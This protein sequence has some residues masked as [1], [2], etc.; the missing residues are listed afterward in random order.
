MAIGLWLLATGSS[1]LRAS[2]RA[3]TRN[4]LNAEGL[5]EAKSQ[6]P[7]AKMKEKWQTIITITRTCNST[8]TTR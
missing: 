4:L 3:Q 8:S 5:P 1:I 6:E 7:E 2:L